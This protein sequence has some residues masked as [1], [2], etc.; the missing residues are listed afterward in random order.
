MTIKAYIKLVKG[1]CIDEA[2]RDSQHVTVHVRLTPE[3]KDS[4]D[5]DVLIKDS[6]EY[7]AD[8]RS[9]A[10]PERCTL[11]EMLEV[12]SARTDFY[13]LSDVPARDYTDLKACEEQSVVIMNTPR[14]N[15]ND[16]AELVFVRFLR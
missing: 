7:H 2:Y 14:P 16:F 10:R 6:E 12:L 11:A 8:Q 9:A 4:I 13:Y 15:D 3:T 1:V 5:K